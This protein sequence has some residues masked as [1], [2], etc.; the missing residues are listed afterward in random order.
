MSTHTSD[1]EMTFEPDNQP[2]TVAHVRLAMICVRDLRSDR[3]LFVFAELP[4]H[5]TAPRSAN[6]DCEDLGVPVRGHSSGD[7]QMLWSL[8]DESSDGGLP[9]FWRNGADVGSAPHGLS[10]VWPSAAN[11]AAV[12]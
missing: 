11:Y 5:P 4:L 6:A 1:E 7:P 8:R 10:R 2:A 12:R 9:L 3:P